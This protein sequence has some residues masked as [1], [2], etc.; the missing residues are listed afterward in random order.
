VVVVGGSIVGLTAKMDAAAGCGLGSTDLAASI[1]FPNPPT[2]LSQYLSFSLQ[3]HPDTRWTEL[4]AV[5]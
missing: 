3:A 1:Y 4:A 2:E 5:R